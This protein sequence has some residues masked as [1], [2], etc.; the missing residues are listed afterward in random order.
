L[1]GATVLR[2]GGDI[3]KRTCG[4]ANARPA[5]AGIG[6]RRREHGNKKYECRKESRV[7]VRLSRVGF[8]VTLSVCSICWVPVRAPDKI[9]A[10]RRSG[11]ILRGFLFHHGRQEPPRAI[12]RRLIA[13]FTGVAA[14]SNG[15]RSP[16][17][18]HVRA[19]NHCI[20][21]GAIPNCREEANRISSLPGEW[22]ASAGDYAAPRIVG[23]RDDRTCAR[24]KFAR[25]SD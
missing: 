14:R 15:Q 5:T 21:L 3:L 19:F 10:H 23:R 12:R 20:R 11:P 4:T 18:A 2:P 13:D 17:R 1:D 22:S 7:H 9:F 24:S 25:S 16:S 6:C 8:A